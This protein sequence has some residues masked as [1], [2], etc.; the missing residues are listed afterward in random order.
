MISFDE[1][2]VAPHDVYQSAG[3]LKSEGRAH[4]CKGLHILEASLIAIVLADHVGSEVYTK[5]R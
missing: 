5:N 4:V 3:V 1:G 2:L